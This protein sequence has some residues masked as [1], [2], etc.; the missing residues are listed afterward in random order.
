MV[1]FSSGTSS[2]TAQ[3][4]KAG[5]YT[6]VVINTANGCSSTANTSVV[7]DRIIPVAKVAPAE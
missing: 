2:H 4:D 6:L 1:I 3:V 5:T 7:E